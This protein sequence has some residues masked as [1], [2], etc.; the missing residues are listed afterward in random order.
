MAEQQY[1]LG[2][3]TELA[4]IKLIDSILSYLDDKKNIKTLVALFLDL[5]KA[6]DN[7]EVD[8][9]L[10]KLQYYGL[11]YNALDLIKS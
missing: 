4:P 3:S 8:I 11:S 2:H 5:S 10:T 6:F 1:G 7:L 9:L